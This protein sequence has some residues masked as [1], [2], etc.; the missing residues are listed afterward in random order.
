MTT[1]VL[2]VPSVCRLL[3]ARVGGF[4]RAHHHSIIHICQCVCVFDLCT[5]MCVLGCVSLCLQD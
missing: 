4:A 1:G 5:F 2:S 3:C